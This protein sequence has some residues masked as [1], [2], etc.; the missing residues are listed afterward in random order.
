MAGSD[1]FSFSDELKVI[2]NNSSSPLH[3]CFEFDSRNGNIRDFQHSHRFFEII[4][5]LDGEGSQTIEGEYYPFKK[6]DIA[7]FSPLLLHK[8]DYPLNK[9]YR[10]LIISF[11]IPSDEPAMASL[12]APLLSLF[13][14]KVPIYRLPEAGRNRLFSI[15]NEIFT[16][17]IQRHSLIDTTAH[18][19]FLEFLCE[20]YNLRNQNR[21]VRESA[22]DSAVQRIYS[23]TSYI[24]ANFSQDFSLKELSEFTYMSPHYLSRLFK[25]VTGFTL[26]HYMQM[27]RVQNAQHLLLSTSK[28]ISEIAELCG[29]ASFSQ[30]NRAFRKFNTTSPSGFRK[31]SG[32]S[33]ADQA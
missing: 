1:F 31:E 3:Y 19:K 18:I 14:K 2:V 13:N 17:K 11:C 33:E 26:V 28:T 24:H 10:R 27:T 12:I 15:L 9:F 4:I 20:L 6:Y 8:T 32:R 21:Y 16:L 29:F 7:F 5:L 22:V 30:F 23:L 25:R